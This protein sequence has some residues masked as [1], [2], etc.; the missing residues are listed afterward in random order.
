MWCL[1][2]CAGSIW[3]YTTAVAKHDTTRH[4]GA[5]SGV[6]R[7]LFDQ[8]ADNPRNGLIIADFAVA[9]TMARQVLD[10]PPEVLTR[11]GL[12]VR[13][14]HDFNSRCTEMPDRATCSRVLSSTLSRSSPA[15]RCMYVCSLGSLWPQASMRMSND[16]DNRM[17]G[18]PPVVNTNTAAVQVPL[19]MSVDAISFSA[20]AD[21]PQTSEFVAALRPPHVVLVH[22]EATNMQR[23]RDALAQQA[24]LPCTAASCHVL[25]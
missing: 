3:L 23:L 9:G 8:W 6:S 13:A 2:S 1:L 11:S 10:S 25:R 12:K 17:R 18:A 15:L 19:R 5:Q 4:P 16:A 21:F 14:A 20:H 7:E 22:G 24:R